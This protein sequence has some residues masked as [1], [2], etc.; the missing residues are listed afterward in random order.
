[1]LA[2]IKIHIIISEELSVSCYCRELPTTNLAEQWVC[3]VTYRERVVNVTCTNASLAGT[4]PLHH[5]QAA[6]REPGCGSGKRAIQEIPLVQNQQDW[7]W[8]GDAL[9]TERPSRQQPL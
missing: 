4:V 9:L 2:T 1:M 5:P 7:H 8:R 3:V 6:G